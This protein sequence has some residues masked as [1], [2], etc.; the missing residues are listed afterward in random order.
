MFLATLALASA[1]PIIDVHRH[2]GWSYSDREEVLRSQLSLMRKS[3]ISLAVVSITSRDDS[4]RWKGKPV[5]VGVKPF[6]PRSLVEPRYDCFPESEG[7][8]DLDWL[9][10]EIVAGRV[11]ALHELA[12]N[13]YGISANNPR[14]SP[15][16]D[17]ASKHDLPVGIHTQR[18]PG[19]NGKFTSRAN[20]GCCPDYDPEMG[21]PALLRPVL[22]RHPNL[23]VWIQ[24]VGSG[25]AGEV[26]SPYWEETMALLADYPNVYLDLS[27]TNGA[28]PTAQY[29]AAL[30]KLIEAGFGDRI[31]FGS[32]NLPVAP[33]L[34]RLDAIEWLGE[35]QKRAI[36][37]D[38][39]ARFFR[40]YD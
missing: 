13:Y 39:A 27:I 1:P 8:A 32:D 20:P 12:P 9:E 33:I 36:L 17:L 30:A 28:M 14:L 38:N 5:I 2:A 21:N 19:P 6:C 7:W 22:E 3:G 10:G 34:A 31:M 40:L 16:W 15:Y 25:R 18:G 23:R 4:R 37:Y 24:H 11:Q 29:E 35:A 26:T